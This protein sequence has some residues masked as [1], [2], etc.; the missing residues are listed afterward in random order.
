V[1]P[2]VIA[3]KPLEKFLRRVLD[4]CKTAYSSRIESEATKYARSDKNSSIMKKQFIV[5]STNNT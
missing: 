1:G 3:L 4:Y 5:V 2:F